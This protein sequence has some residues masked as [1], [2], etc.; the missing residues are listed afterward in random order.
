MAVGMSFEIVAR[1]PGSRARR[2]RL[3][4]P[5]G[6]VETPAFMPV[7]TYGAVKG[8]RAQDLQ[9][10]GVQI[11]L[12]NA[13]HLAE[14]PG[15]ELVARLGGLHR[16]I[17]WSG[18]ILTDSGGYQVFSL[19]DRCEVDDGGV[20]F[21]SP[22]DGSRQRLTPETVVRIQAQLGSDIAM[23]LDECVA[24]P[25]ERGVAERAVRRSQAWAERSV[26]LKD[27]LPGG[28]FGIVQG[29]D[30]ADLRHGHA[31]ALADLEFDGYAVGGLSVGEDKA[32]TWR[33]LEAA[34]DGLPEERPHYV[35]GM[36]T[37]AD[38]VEGVYRGADLFDCVIPTRHARNGTA[39]TAEGPI[40]IRNA[41]FADDDRPLDPACT[42]PTCERYGRAYLRH[43]ATRGEML[44]PILLTWHNLARYLDT[45]RTIRQ[46]VESAALTDL[47]AAL[48]GPAER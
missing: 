46:A 5:H 12:G 47:R 37:P 23:V 16:F 20:T 7:G 3:H 48:A 36:G 34:I 39:F 1:E 27:E 33:M 14:R 19:A 13:Y 4:T 26:A 43:L 24:S 22:L 18:P 45:M 41:R 40:N 21:R 17:G 29:S 25:A 6:V 11:V 10:L 38:L 30:H 31:R 44:G 35:M 42:C 32:R 15:A 28:L 8:M 9:E 2:G